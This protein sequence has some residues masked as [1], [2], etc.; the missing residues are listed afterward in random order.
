MTPPARL[1]AFALV[2][3]AAFGVGAAVGAA[4]GPEPAADAPTTVE[5]ED[6]HP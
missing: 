1:G 3:A 5:H 6:V 2:L 4:V